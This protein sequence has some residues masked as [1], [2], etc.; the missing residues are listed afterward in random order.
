M[1]RPPFKGCAGVCIFE[2]RQNI[3]RG[4]KSQQLIPSRKANEQ[5]AWYLQAETDVDGPR[6]DLR[7]NDRAALPLRVDSVHHLLDAVLVVLVNKSGDKVVVM[8]CFI[9]MSANLID[10]RQCEIGIK[11]LMNDLENFSVLPQHSAESVELLVSAYRLGT[12]CNCSSM[13][14]KLVDRPIAP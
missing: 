2:G 14:T 10:P 9:E 13:S 7:P 1:V 6:L 4:R 8:P 3:L 11:K 12:G 5:Q